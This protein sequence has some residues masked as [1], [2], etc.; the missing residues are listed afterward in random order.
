MDS[1]EERVGDLV[2]RMLGVEHEVG[3]VR[4]AAAETR[5]GGVTV[6]Q[7]ATRVESME[8]R[9][10]RLDERMIVGDEEVG[11]LAGCMEQRE[12]NVHGRFA[13]QEALILDYVD[14]GGTIMNEKLNVLAEVVNS[15][16]G[17]HAK[18]LEAELQCIDANVHKRF[19]KLEACV[20]GFGAKTVNNSLWVDKIVPHAEEM[21]KRVVALERKALWDDATVAESVDYD[22]EE[23]APCW[24]ATS[25]R[26]ADY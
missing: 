8:E 23:E 2:E 10:G 21:Q 14:E 13:E 24:M 5:G 11:E 16:R 20:E 9:V 1:M 25:G 12:V 22:V 19:C 7:L 6:E 18:A 3:Q 15:G 26:S 17:A 4:E